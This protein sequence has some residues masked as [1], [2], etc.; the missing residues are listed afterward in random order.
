MCL[1]HLLVYRADHLLNHYRNLSLIVIRYFT[2]VCL[3]YYRHCNNL[4]KLNISCSHYYYYFIIIDT[5]LTLQ[6]FCVSCLIVFH[7]FLHFVIH[8]PFLLLVPY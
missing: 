1:S 5:A 6:N 8:P 4:A 7:I 3:I 2:C